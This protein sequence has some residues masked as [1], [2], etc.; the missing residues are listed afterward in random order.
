MPRISEKIGN[1]CV[2]LLVTV[3]PHTQ[4][5]SGVGRASRLSKASS[6]SMSAPRMRPLVSRVI[7]ALSLIALGACSEPP[8]KREWRASDHGQPSVEPSGQSEGQDDSTE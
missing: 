1:V 5:A 2:M 4:E 3:G 8:P 6:P 7:A